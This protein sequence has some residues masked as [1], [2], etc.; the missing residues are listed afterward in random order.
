MRERLGH[1]AIFSVQFAFGMGDGDPAVA[2]MIVVTGMVR[3]IIAGPG[4]WPPHRFPGL[5][6]DLD[7]GQGFAAPFTK[8]TEPGYCSLPH[9]RSKT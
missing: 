4:V 3:E 1:S 8:T 5:S 7:L 6:V 9:T 2:G